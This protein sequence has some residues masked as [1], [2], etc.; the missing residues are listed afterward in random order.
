MARSV[1]QR[2]HGKYKSVSGVSLATATE[3]VQIL[4]QRVI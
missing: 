4:G 3:A 1:Q 2:L